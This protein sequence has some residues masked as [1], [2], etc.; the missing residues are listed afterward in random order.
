MKLFSIGTFLTIFTLA[1]AGHLHQ[2]ATS[3]AMVTRYEP[4]EHK[5]WTAHAVDNHEWAG[6]DSLSHGQNGHHDGQV[7]YS[8][9]VDDASHALSPGV[10]G[11]QDYHFHPKYNIIKYIVDDSK[12]NDDK[13]EKWGHSESHIWSSADASGS[14]KHGNNWSS[15]TAKHA[16]NS[17]G[18]SAG[19]KDSYGHDLEENN[20]HDYHT[21]P[22]YEFQYGVKDAK[23]GDIKDQWEHR[24]GDKVKGN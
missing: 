18:W 5:S 13:N 4:V 17:H 10:E 19:V 9:E 3:Y 23:T 8:T 21:H 6:I 12:T 15:N 22:K 14:S 7:W 11:H 1:A 24:D 2:D 20:Q 16:D